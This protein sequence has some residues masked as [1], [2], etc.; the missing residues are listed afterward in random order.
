MLL[1][2]FFEWA[3]FKQWFWIFRWKAVRVTG[4]LSTVKVRRSEQEFCMWILLP[5]KFA[6]LCCHIFWPA[7]A[8]SYH[9]QEILL[10]WVAKYA[11][12]IFWAEALLCTSQHTTLTLIMGHVNSLLWNHDA[13]KFRHSNILP[14]FCKAGIVY[15]NRADCCVASKVSLLQ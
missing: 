11:M 3:A 2:I 13:I 8:L 12:Q 15:A 9:F 6:Y 5:R 7:K 1:F 14:S 10:R 4:N